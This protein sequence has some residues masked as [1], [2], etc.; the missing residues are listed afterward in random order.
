MLDDQ[1]TS[2][3]TVEN[4]GLDMFWGNNGGEYWTIYVWG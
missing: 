3:D 4:L 1:Q 2:I